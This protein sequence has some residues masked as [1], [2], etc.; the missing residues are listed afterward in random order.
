VL[1]IAHRQAAT[2][3]AAIAGA[4]AQTYRPIEVI[5]S[6]DASQDD[7]SQRIEGAGCSLGSAA[8]AAIERWRRGERRFATPRHPLAYDLDVAAHVEALLALA[9]SL[10]P[11]LRS[12]G[13]Q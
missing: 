11:N 9:G 5:V 2:I 13:A 1:L 7:T 10:L 6:D 12:Q 3:E 8:A 4:L